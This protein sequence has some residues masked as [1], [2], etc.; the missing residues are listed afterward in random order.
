MGQTV[1]SFRLVTTEKLVAEGQSIELQEKY[2]KLGDAGIQR[3]L[4]AAAH[5]FS[6]REKLI[7]RQETDEFRHQANAIVETHCLAQHTHL[8]ALSMVDASLWATAVHLKGALATDEWL[9]TMASERVPYDDEGN[10]RFEAGE[11]WGQTWLE[12]R[13]GFWM[14]SSNTL[15]ACR[16]SLI[17]A[18]AGLQVAPKGYGDR[19]RVIM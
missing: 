10:A 14:Q 7:L 16:R 4:K 13:T 3:E 2:P 9:L 8:R 5:K 12:R 19:G 15:F 18:L 1:A 11:A 6:S 17:P